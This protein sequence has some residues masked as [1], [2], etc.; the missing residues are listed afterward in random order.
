MLQTHSWSFIAN[1]CVS[2]HASITRVTYTLRLLR[3]LGPHGIWSDHTHCEQIAGITTWHDM[4]NRTVERLRGKKCT[5]SVK[6]IRQKVVQTMIFQRKID[7]HLWE[8]IGG[9]PLAQHIPLSSP[10]R[11]RGHQ[12]DA[13]DEHES[14]ASPWR[15][16]IQDVNGTNCVTNFIPNSSKCCLLVFDCQL[17]SSPVKYSQVMS[18][19]SSSR[20]PNFS[21]YF[22]W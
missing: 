7:F 15:P 4:A 8:V 14:L 13:R 22:V 9:N 19:Y 2:I 1:K 12:H 20:R 5:K 10:D 6:K 18:G 11:R 21:F 3:L 17:K 16:W